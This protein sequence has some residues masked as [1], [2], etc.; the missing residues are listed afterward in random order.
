MRKHLVL[1]A[2]VVVALWPVDQGSA[3]QK[4]QA[5]QESAL[6]KLFDPETM[7]KEH[8]KDLGG[9]ASRGTGSRTGI[10]VTPPGH[11][12]KDGHLQGRLSGE[13]VK[14]ILAS[15]QAEM[16]KL[17]ERSKVR[18]VGKPKDTILDLPIS[19]LRVVFGGLGWVNIA[20]LQGS[21]FAYSEGNIEGTVQVIAANM[22]R[23]DPERWTISWAVH[24]AV[25]GAK[26]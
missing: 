17:A 11:I 9:V 19:Y 4:G 16:V 2:F 24:E 21:Y 8:E 6:Y 20:S 5:Q 7:A 13:Q 23:D 10:K 12:F 18:I 25:R 1:V 26:E 14:T 3:D 15:L 22:D